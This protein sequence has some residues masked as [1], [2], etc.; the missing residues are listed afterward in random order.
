MAFL[1]ATLSSHELY[2]VP[3]PRALAGAA[4]IARDTA[5]LLQQAIDVIWPKST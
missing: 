4:N 3:D 2:E 5:R 1:A